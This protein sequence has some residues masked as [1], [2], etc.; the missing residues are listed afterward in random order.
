MTTKPYRADFEYIDEIE[1]VCSIN[2]NVKCLWCG[3][4]VFARGQWSDYPAV[5][6]GLIDKYPNLYISF[7]PELVSGKYAGITREKALELAETVI[8]PPSPTTSLCAC[9]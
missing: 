7:T 4:G 3:A 5:V 9:I 8:S 1:M 2:K 6:K